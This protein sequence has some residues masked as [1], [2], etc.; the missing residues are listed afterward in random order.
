MSHLTKTEVSL[1]I[2]LNIVTMLLEV[3]A[4]CP[5]M[6]EKTSTPIVNCIVNNGLQ[7]SMLCQTRRNAGSVHNTCLDKCCRKEAARCFV[8]VISFTTIRRPQVLLQI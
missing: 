5:H 6:R 1:V 3:S 2:W 4:F 8:S 7:W